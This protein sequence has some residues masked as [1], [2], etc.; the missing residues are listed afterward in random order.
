MSES[1]SKKTF[2]ISGENYRA[3]CP[4]EFEVTL[5]VGFIL[6]SV[7]WQCFLLKIALSF[8]LPEFS[9]VALIF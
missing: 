3:T 9:I 2:F 5:L 6:T 7:F 1:D 8:G 4:L